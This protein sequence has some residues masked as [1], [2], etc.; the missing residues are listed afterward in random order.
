MGEAIDKAKA[1]NGGKPKDPTKA[2]A[3]P[4]TKPAPG[5]QITGSED[6]FLSD[7][8]RDALGEI[9][10]DLLRFDGQDKFSVKYWADLLDRMEKRLNKVGRA[11]PFNAHDNGF[12][13][14]VWEHFQTASERLQEAASQL[15]KKRRERDDKARPD[16]A[17]DAAVKT[18]KIDPKKVILLDLDDDGNPVPDKKPNKKPVVTKE[19]DPKKRDLTPLW[20]GLILVSLLLGGLWVLTEKPFKGMFGGSMF[21]FITPTNNVM[22]D[23]TSAG[24]T[25]K[26]QNGGPAPVIVIG[27]SN[28]S[29]I[30][31][32]QFYPNSGFGGT[33][34]V[35]SLVSPTNTMV[36]TNVVN[37]TN[38][39]NNSTTT[40]VER[41][42]MPATPLA[43]PVPEYTKPAQWPDGCTP[44][45]V[46]N[47]TSWLECMVA[48]NPNRQ[49]FTTEPEWVMAGEDVQV[50]VPVGWK[51]YWE[52]HKS[53]IYAVDGVQ[54]A[55][56]TAGGQ[57]HD[58][59]FRHRV[60]TEEKPADFTLFFQRL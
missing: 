46:I 11:G 55:P 8:D 23:V 51:A 20:V 12:I 56:K 19:E 33:S 9:E 34:V 31:N 53:L 28:V 57:H 60:V 45:R 50:L 25:M 22:L 13:Y 26:L 14:S 7:D 40:I 21:S 1:A 15:E 44:T 18:G 32:N 37:V 24:G 36:V 29:V 59:R 10:K 39:F 49:L 4:P 42:T 52:K 17:G 41:V 43:V 2:P 5:S 48:Q 16:D 30:A 58:V 3:A 6:K 47:P 54:D 38:T 27:S 35:V